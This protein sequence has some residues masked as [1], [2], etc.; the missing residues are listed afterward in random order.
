MLTLPKIAKLKKHKI[1]LEKYGNFCCSACITKCLKIEAKKKIFSQEKVHPSYRHHQ[2]ICGKRH[3]SGRGCSCKTR[4]NYVSIV[5]VKIVVLLQHKLS[6]VLPIFLPKCTTKLLFF[7]VCSNFW[8]SLVACHFG[9]KSTG[10]EKRKRIQKNL[11]LV[12]NIISN[13][14]FFSPLV[15][16][17]H[18]FKLH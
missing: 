2:S 8:R 5:F 13:T 1:S 4:Q 7:C 6:L 11:F 15:L 3:C 12:G 16:A 17:L 18:I 9:W 10:H 14:L